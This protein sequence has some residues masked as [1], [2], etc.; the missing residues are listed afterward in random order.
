MRIYRMTATFG[1]LEHQ[2]LTL[3]PGLNVICREN[4]WGKTTWSA[5]LLAMLYGL[6]TRAKSTKTALADKER[7]APWS[8]SPMAGRMDICWNGRDITIER[9]TRGRVPMG[10]FRAYETESGMAVPELTAANCGQMLLGVEQSVFRRAGFIRQAE[11]PVTQDEALRRRLNALVTTGDESPAGERLERSL[12]ELKNKCRYNRTGLLPTAEAERDQ[13]EQT[14]EELTALEQQNRKL[15]QRLGEIT[16]W[17]AQLQGHL[18]VLRYEASREDARRVEEARQ[19]WQQAE[20]TLERCRQ[21]CAKLPDRET[22]EQKL[23]Q[24]REFQQQWN[25]LQ[26]EAQLLPPL[27]EKPECPGFLSGEEPYRVAEDARQYAALARRKSGLGAFLTAAACLVLGAVLMLWQA[28]V[29]LAAGLV[30]GLVFCI[31]GICSRRRRRNAMD[32]LAEKYGSR[33]PELWLASLEAYQQALAEYQAALAHCHGLRGDVDARLTALRTKQQSLCGA[34][35]PDKVVELWQQVLQRWEEYHAARRESQRAQ[36]HLQTL[37]A[38]AKPAAAPAEPDELTFAPEETA[39]LISDAQQEKYRLENRMAKTQGRME[40]L[41]QREALEGKRQLTQERIRHL[42]QTLAAAELGL[43]TL[44]QA[45]RELQRRFAPRI[46]QRAQSI[47][48]RLTEGRYH[49]LLLDE[50]FS[51]LTGAEQ[52]QILHPTLWRSDGTADQMYLALRLAVAQELTPGTPLVL[53]DAFVRFDDRRLKAAL[54]IL[55]EMAL[56]RQ[57]LLFTCQSRESNLL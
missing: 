48:S 43:R 52:E 29:Y 40:A 28:P 21:S 7:Y 24:L 37:E 57:I 18:Q 9:T 36:S 11:M 5:F 41:G 17:E 20:Q 56:E 38:M 34:Q 32:A 2:T 31:I 27:P 54:D 45:R 39:R 26:L 30:P 12:R 47:L 33:E 35:L 55:S 16:R 44:A 23:R 4:E 50:D 1:K 49:R 19:E 51:V 6:D 42:E 8:G 53:D 14:L 10:E 15:F 22:A 3:E 25:A 46:A 13:L